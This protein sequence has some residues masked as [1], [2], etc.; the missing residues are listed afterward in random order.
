[1]TGCGVELAWD[2]SPAYL[3][4]RS[5][6]P[7]AA[8]WTTRYGER[9][10]TVL[11]PEVVPRMF[12]GSTDFGNVSYRVPGVH[13]MVRITDADISLH[14]REFADAAV[15]EE[16]DRVVARLGLGA[17]RRGRRLAVRPRAARG[18][19]PPTSRRP[20]APSTSPP[21]SGRPEPWPPTTPP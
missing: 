11:P 13:A 1:M 17:G 19:P 2:E 9:G 10:R 16:A 3:P 14:T 20:A 4:V 18:A 5:S 6:G 21:T 15:S 7:L 8:A 12:A